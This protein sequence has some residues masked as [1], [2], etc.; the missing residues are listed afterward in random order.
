MMPGNRMNGKAAALKSLAQ[1]VRAL[2]RWNRNPRHE[3]SVGA[4]QGLDPPHGEAQVMEAVRRFAAGVAHDLNNLLLVV[5]GY[6]EMAL[7]EEDAGPQTLAHL[8]E[9]RAAS[10]RAAS[11]AEDLLTVGQRGRI[12]PR[13]LQLNESISRL[14]PTVRAQASDGVEVR[15]SLAPVLPAV[16]SDDEQIARLVAA[17]CARAWSAMPAGGRLTIG[18]R[19]TEPDPLGQRRV[20]LTFADTGTPVPPDLRPRLFEPFPP[21][22]ADSKGSGLELSIAYSI[23]HRLGGTID[24]ENPPEGGAKFVIS[25][26]VRDEEPAGHEGSMQPSEE[27]PSLLRRAATAPVEPGQSILLAEDDEGLRTLARKILAREGYEVLVASDGQEAVDLFEVNRDTVRLALIDEVMPRMGGRAAL[28]RMRRSVPGL[29]AILCTGYTW[30]L[31]GKTQEGGDILDILPKPWRPR[32]LLRIVRETLEA[33]AGRL[34][35]AGD[36]A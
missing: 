19:A 1:R 21:W 26:P 28:A 24:V 23:V 16:F 34:P 4:P 36:N 22:R 27:M 25:F 32:E 18:T 31:D 9:V 7:A 15:L 17:L 14:L 5:Q 10:V 11:L 13:M 30:S 33:R 29:P 12:S 6:T 2:L 3:G 8:A 20:L 35:G